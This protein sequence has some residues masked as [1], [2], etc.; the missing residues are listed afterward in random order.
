[1]RLD[2]SLQQKLSLQLK[3]A[4]Q[5]IQSI[6]ILQL[7]ALNLKEMIDQELMENEALEIQ[8]TREETEPGPLAEANRESHEQ[9]DF[10]ET[11]ERLERMI[12]AEGSYEG[13]GRRAPPS[14]DGRDRKLEA[15]Q[16]T[17][18]RAPGLKESLI[19]Q[20][21]WVDV[22]ERL[23]PLVRG[24]IY[25][26]DDDGY[27]LYPL[28]DVVRILNSNLDGG[29]PYSAEEAEEALRI[30][31]GLEPRGVGAR[32]IV[33]ALLLQ[34]PDDDPRAEVKRRL[35]KEFLEDINKNR[36]PRV[37][38]EM[39]MSIEEVSSLVAEIASLDPRPGSECSSEEVHYIVPD[40]VILWVDGEYEV[41]L[42]DTYF[43]SL[44]ISPRYLKMLHDH[45][46]DPKV[47]EHIKKKIESARWLIDSIEQ[48]QNTLEKVV[49]AIVRRQRDFL[50]FGISHLRPLKMQEIADELG[51]HVSTVSR[52]IADKYVQCHRGIFPLKF[53][54][55]GGTEVEGGAVESRASVKQKVKE[56]IEGE[57]RKNP[58][59]DE[60]IAR[61]L[62]DEGLNI[63]RRTVTKYRKQL[64]IPSSR[65]RRVWTDQG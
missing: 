2:I 53:F 29:E 40:V 52:A 16:N 3:L 54:F 26:L 28:D 25:S 59:S 35:V 55:T 7:P 64:G 15:I 18:A 33:E 6:E 47:R 63:A 1:M 36:L 8:E 24:I 22:P 39:G 32:D 43:P 20:L 65:Q 60:E 62:R 57:D 17:P 23:L 50:D 49:R 48:R 9:D 5:I 30:V 51:I 44:R 4:P 21:A 38:R 14:E 13:G 42:E 12:E 58:L 41:R 45:R 61:R 27:L 19:A 34:I 56:I 31:Q 37:A 46:Q 10:E 11:Y